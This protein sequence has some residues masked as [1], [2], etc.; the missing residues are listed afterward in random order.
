MLAALVLTVV[1]V[2]MIGAA[3]PLARTDE[4]PRDWELEVV[5]YLWISATYGTI[6]VRGRTAHVSLTPLDLLESVFDGDALAGATYASL[7]WR[8]FSLFVDAFGAGAKDTQRVTVPTPRCNLDLDAKVR[9]NQVFV[10][11]GL[12]AEVG[13]WPLPERRRPISLGVYA[14]MRY[15]H[16]GSHIDSTAS[17][18][19]LGLARE[20]EASV[21]YDWADPLVGVRFEV[22]LHD[23]LSLDFRG[24]IGG[25]G[26]SSDLIWGLV[27]TVRYWMKWNP[28]G[29]RPWLGAG[30]RVAAFDRGDSDATEA[31]MQFRGPMTALGIVF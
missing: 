7:R 25:F 30:Y 11:V 6:D 24:D 23:R 27:G 17:I 2:P 18:D 3:E 28:R 15:V 12:G 26:A 21:T 5:P 8:R 22:P 31:D 14:G 16:L 9:V 1:T 4:A 29:V 20:T 10:D 19:Q 13:R